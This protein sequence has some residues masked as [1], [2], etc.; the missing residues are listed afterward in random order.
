MI[1]SL[2]IKNL[3]IVSDTHID[4]HDGF[5]VI[6]GES[7]SGKSIICDAIDLI[8]GEKA[9]N[10]MIRHGEQMASISADFVL[11]DPIPELCQPYVRGPIP[12]LRITRYLYQTQ[13]S[14][15]EINGQASSLAT[16]KVLGNI[17]LS[18]Q[19]Q[20]AQTQLLSEHYYLDCLDSLIGDEIDTLL[21]EYRPV[22][23][24]YEAARQEEN[25]LL[26]ANNMD[27]NYRAF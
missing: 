18:V 15:C 14:R 23:E 24:D 19:A 12:Q 10:D 5:T 7:G 26:A 27:A 17:L 11:S 8:R 21:Q 16:L 25:E 20:H 6:T 3:A 9:S 22:W 2:D 13:R 4:F 1:R